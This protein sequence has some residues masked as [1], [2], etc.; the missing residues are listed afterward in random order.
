MSRADE[1]SYIRPP[2]AGAVHKNVVGTT[3]KVFAT[4][5]EWLGRKVLFHAEGGDLF[6]NFGTAITVEV[7]RAGVST[8]NSTT[9]GLTV[10]A[11]AGGRIPENG[12]LDFDVDRSW[13]YF[14]VESNEATA[15]WIGY[16]S[17]IF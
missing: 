17:S 1:S 11:T 12:Y 9:K 10:A 14:A 3:H 6:L 2:Y 7:D 8:W 16:P 15:Y 4:P 5:A 13:T